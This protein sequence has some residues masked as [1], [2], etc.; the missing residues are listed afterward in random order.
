MFFDQ[1]IGW[2]TLPNIFNVRPDVAGHYHKLLGF[3]MYALVHFR[4]P[5]DSLPS[6]TI[7]A[8]TR[9][10]DVNETWIRSGRL[11]VIEGLF[12]VVKELA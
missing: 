3:L 5:T 12:Q 7:V 8:L 1:D 6:S 2:K 9:K 4:R 10:D 11:V